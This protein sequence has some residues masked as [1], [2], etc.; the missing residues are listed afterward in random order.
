MKRTL[1]A[2]AVLILL[3]NISVSIAGTSG[4]T[5]IWSGEYI[6]ADLDQGGGWD[7]GP[8]YSQPWTFDFDN[9]TAD[10]VNTFPVFGGEYIFHDAT[11]TDNNDGTYSGVILLD[12]AIDIHV[13]NDVPIDITW[14]INNSGIVT[15]IYGKIPFDSSWMPNSNMQFDGYI[16]PIP[17]PAAIWLFGS[18][19]LGLI[20]IARRKKAA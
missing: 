10:I 4:L 6:W 1:L 14:D 19:L 13:H 3:G 12:V 11:F 8:D 15:T 7:F 20:G 16:N 17:I 9:G 5:G 18:G 2:S